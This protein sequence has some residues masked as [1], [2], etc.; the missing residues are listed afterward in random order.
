ME[1][2]TRYVIRHCLDPHCIRPFPLLSGYLNLPGEGGSIYFVEEND[3]RLGPH[4]Q[5]S[6]AK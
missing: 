5:F 3:S 2:R 6:S 1:R 4:D